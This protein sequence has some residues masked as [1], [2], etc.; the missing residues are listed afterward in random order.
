AVD[1]IK[2]MVGMNGVVV[3]SELSFAYIKEWLVGGNIFF[4]GITYIIG[5]LFYVFIA[6]CVMQIKNYKNINPLSQ[7]N[8]FFAGI[9]FMFCLC[10]LSKK[11]IFIY[12]NF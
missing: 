1:L 7:K 12:F 4:V 8:C 3:P 2:G 9:L 10:F 6:I 11:Q 5:F